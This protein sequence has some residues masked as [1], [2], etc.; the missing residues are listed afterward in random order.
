[1]ECP[2]CKADIDEELVKVIMCGQ[3]VQLVCDGCG[4]VFIQNLK[5]ENWRRKY[6]LVREGSHDYGAIAG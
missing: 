4:E 6:N 5:P 1:M 2:E 3:V